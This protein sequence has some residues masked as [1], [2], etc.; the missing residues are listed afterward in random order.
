[1]TFRKCFWT[2]ACAGA[3]GASTAP[4]IAAPLKEKAPPISF[5]TRSPSLATV[6]TQALEWLKSTDKADA[7]TLARFDKIWANDEAPLIDRLADTLSLGSADAAKALAEAKTTEGMAPQD[8]PDLIR[9]R[10][11]PTF[12]R[13]N[14]A[15]AYARSLA[16]R[17]IYE[18]SLAVLRTVRAEDTADLAAYHFYRAVGEHALMMR[19]DAHKSLAKLDEI[20]D[21]PER[22]QAVAQLMRLHMAT[23]QHKDIDWIG[24]KMNNVER[25]L[26]LSR[27]GPQTQRMQKEIIDAL[28]DLIRENE[29]PTPPGPVHRCGPPKPGIIP[30]PTGPRPSG[31]GEVKKIIGEKSGPWGE[32]PEKE[33]IKA[34]QSGVRDLPPGTRKLIEDYYK[35]QAAQSTIR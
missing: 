27:I 30:G 14:L 5:E 18:E 3:I 12:L 22:Y 26:D 1:M 4:V 23:W 34:M 9:D 32:L 21:A 25:R 31:P 11:Q 29:P 13:A 19:D 16:N 6:K 8:V 10:K 2:L 17:R 20:S 35:K 28:D 15:L 33:R 24:R 7:A